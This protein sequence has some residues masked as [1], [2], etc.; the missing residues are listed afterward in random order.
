[1]RERKMEGMNPIKIYCKHIGK[2]HNV[3]SL[4]NYFMQIK[5]TM[6]R[7]TPKGK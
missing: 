7:I 4:Y 3:S 1:M 6:K 5:K 2:Y